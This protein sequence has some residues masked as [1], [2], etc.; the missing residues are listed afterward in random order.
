M[1][2]GSSLLIHSPAAYLFLLS[3]LSGDF[4]VGFC[5]SLDG[6]V[7]FAPTPPVPTYRA[8]QKI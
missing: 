6:A 3:V 7:A 8:T 5:S 4:S 1:L 2:L